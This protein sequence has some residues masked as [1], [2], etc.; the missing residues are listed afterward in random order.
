MPQDGYLE[1]LNKLASQY[2]IKKL[3]NLLQVDNISG[4]T[5]TADLKDLQK[6][7]SEILRRSSLSICTDWLKDELSLRNK[8]STK[9]PYKTKITCFRFC[10]C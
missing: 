8:K 3:N 2:V 9:V 5:S 7:F 6:V 4:S 1:S 10:F